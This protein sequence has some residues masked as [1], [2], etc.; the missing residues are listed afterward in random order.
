MRMEAVI[1]DFDGVIL[2][3]VGVKTAAFAKL[4]EEYGATAVRLMTE[5]HEANGGISRYEKF[6]WFF[7]NVLGRE[8]SAAES[9]AW[10]ERFE[11]YAFRGVLAAPFIQGAHEFLTSARNARKLFVASGTPETELCT[12]VERRGLAECFLE[13]RGTPAKKSEIV[14]S[15]M[16]KHA[17]VAERTLF[18]GDAMTD[19]H[20]AAE[21]G[22]PFLGIA[23]AE[24]SRFPEGTP[25][26][27]DLTGLEDFIASGQT[28]R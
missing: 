12:I 17:L 13:V 24:F 1:F 4:V 28:R 21:C 2:D 8:I 11:S 23:P 16:E 27:P 6:A 22:L 5:F 7:Q 26:L 20:A 19:Y 15:L 14:R 3:S 10:G 18:I 25:T 9:C